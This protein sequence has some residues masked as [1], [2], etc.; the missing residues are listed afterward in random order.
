MRSTFMVEGTQVAQVEVNKGETPTAP[1]DPNKAEDDE[2]TYD[3]AGWEPAL[4]A[5]NQDTTYT[6]KFTA[7]PKPVEEK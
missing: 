2:N 3:F 4:G 1:A 7:T 6:A 5:I